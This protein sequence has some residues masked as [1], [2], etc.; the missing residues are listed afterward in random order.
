MRNKYMKTIAVEYIQLAIQKHIYFSPREGGGQFYFIP[1][2]LF[3]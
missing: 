3:I 2:L 1:F